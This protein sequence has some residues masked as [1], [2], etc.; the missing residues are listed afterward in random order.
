M[1]LIRLGYP[2][3]SQKTPSTVQEILLDDVHK[4]LSTLN[5]T[6]DQKLDKEVSPEIASLN[7][8]SRRNSFDAWEAPP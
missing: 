3:R 8:Q 7:K 1:P 5:S 2:M 4:A 6:E